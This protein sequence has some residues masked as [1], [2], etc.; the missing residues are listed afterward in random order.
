M[1]WADVGHGNLPGRV[2]GMSEESR[3]YY[4]DGDAAAQVVA[5]K[6]AEDLSLT[7]SPGNAD[8]Y[9]RFG[10]ASV[11]EGATADSVVVVPTGALG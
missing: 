8:Y 10:E 2:E 7:A 4:P 5:E 11:R 9:D 6:L 3:V 1:G